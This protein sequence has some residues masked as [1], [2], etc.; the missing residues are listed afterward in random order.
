M[1]CYVKGCRYKCQGNQGA[2]RSVPA[3]T[4]CKVCNN[5]FLIPIL[6]LQYI[7]IN[8]DSA[9]AIYLSEYDDS[10]QFEQGISLTF[11]D[12]AYRTLIGA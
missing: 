4:A 7:I 1:K 10:C 11:L 8:Y 9:A 5:L 12:I 6:L 2:R 3:N